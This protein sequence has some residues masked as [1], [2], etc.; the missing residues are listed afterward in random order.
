MTVMHYSEEYRGFTIVQ[1]EKPISL[2]MW[3][4]EIAVGDSERRAQLEEYRKC[5]GALT[6]TPGDLKRALDCA[7]QYIDAVVADTQN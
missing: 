4:L 1:R 6:L 7:R 2:N 5:R 3:Q